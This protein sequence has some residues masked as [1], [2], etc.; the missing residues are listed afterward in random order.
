MRGAD[1]LPAREGGFNV[2]PGPDGKSRS[3]SPRERGCGRGGPVSPSAGQGGA[4]Y[5]VGE[6]EGAGI[7]CGVNGKRRGPRYNRRG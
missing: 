4:G 2:R 1:P 3:P 6:A 7:P 5:A